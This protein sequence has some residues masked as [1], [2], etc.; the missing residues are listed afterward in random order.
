M[1]TARKLYTIDYCTYAESI[2]NTTFDLFWGY[3]A[4]GNQDYLEG[5][6]LLYKGY[7]FFRKYDHMSVFYPSF[8]DM[9][10]SGDMMDN[11][12]KRGIKK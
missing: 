7:V 5:N 10:H 2:K 1:E 6:C 11:A 8:P 12:N 9:R 4:N 3:P